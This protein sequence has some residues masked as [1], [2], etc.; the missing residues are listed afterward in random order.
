MSSMLAK[1]SVSFLA[2]GSGIDMVLSSMFPLGYRAYPNGKKLFFR[3]DQDALRHDWQ[4][5][6]GDMQAVCQDLK[7]GANHVF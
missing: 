1:L 5:I 4:C 6:C 2:V 3:S 7:D